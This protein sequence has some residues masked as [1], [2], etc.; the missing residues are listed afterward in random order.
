MFV[1][2]MNRPNGQYASCYYR[3]NGNFIDFVD[4]KTYATKFDTKERCNCIIDCCLDKY[5]KLYSAAGFE[6]EEE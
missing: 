4:D 6:V 2:K 3:D 1:I 5:K